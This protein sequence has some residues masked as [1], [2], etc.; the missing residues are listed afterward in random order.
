MQKIA[1]CAALYN[2]VGLY[3]RN[4]GTY[5][6]SEKNLLGPKQQYL[7][8]MPLQYGELRPTSGWD[9]FVSLGHPNKCQ[10]VS[11]LGSVTAQPNCGDEQRAPPVFGRAAIIGHWPT[12]LVCNFYT[13]ICSSVLFVFGF[14]YA[15][16][17]DP[18]SCWA[19]VS[20]CNSELSL[21]TLCFKLDLDIL[22]LNQQVKYLDQ[23]S[24]CSQ[25]ILQTHRHHTYHTEFDWLL[26]L[27]VVGTKLDLFSLNKLF[28]IKKEFMFQLTVN[29][30]KQLNF[31]KNLS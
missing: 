20:S 16:V 24:F 23:R 25:V 21:T 12:F 15:T 1:I 11:R 13:H 6:Q 4:W 10:R 28:P 19:V 14:Q 8:H 5:W 27:A 17:G 3:L 26:Y 7:P 9:R 18:S 29:R 22:T 30:E 2:I 31:K